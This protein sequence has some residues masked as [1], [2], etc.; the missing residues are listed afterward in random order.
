[1]DM[2]D[3]YIVYWQFNGTDE[4]KA[5]GPD[6]WD[7]RDNIYYQGKNKYNQGMNYPSMNNASTADELLKQ[8]K[9]FDDNPTLYW[10]S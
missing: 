2:C 7:I 6:K 4:N 3:S 1:M 5:K 8:L 10:I 9:E